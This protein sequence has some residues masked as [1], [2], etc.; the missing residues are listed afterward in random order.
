MGWPQITML[1]IMCID[2]G[3]HIAKHGEEK[4]EKYNAWVAI[5]TA[6]IELSILYAGGFFTK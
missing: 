4:H 6:A 2:I 5:V 3:M 1:C